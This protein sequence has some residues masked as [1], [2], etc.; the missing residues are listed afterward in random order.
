MNNLNYI[1][2][3][4][5]DEVLGFLWDCLEGE[6]LG[7]ASTYFEIIQDIERKYGFLNDRQLI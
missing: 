5:Y 6:H 3:A 7:C 4:L 2:K 1:P